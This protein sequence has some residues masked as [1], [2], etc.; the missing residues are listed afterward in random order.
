MSHNTHGP[1]TTAKITGENL[2]QPVVPNKGPVK[3]NDPISPLLSIRQPQVTAN[4]RPLNSDYQTQIDT[5]TTG[6]N[7][8]V[9]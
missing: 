9:I 7:E 4:H 3:V 6:N 5:R 8:N 2:D 1:N